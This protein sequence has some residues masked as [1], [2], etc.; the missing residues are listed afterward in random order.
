M[1]PN[2]RIFSFNP[3]IVNL[4]RSIKTRL[5]FQKQKD[6]SWGNVTMPNIEPYI[7]VGPFDKSYGRCDHCGFKVK[8]S[9]KGH[10]PW[11]PNI[12][13]RVP[14]CEHLLC[15]DC[16]SQPGELCPACEEKGGEC[17]VIPPMRNIAIERL[18]DI[19]RRILNITPYLRRL[20][21]GEFSRQ[22]T[23]RKRAYYE[24]CE[25]KLENGALSRKDAFTRNF[26]KTEATKH[27]WKLVNGEWTDET[28][29]RN[30]SP[31]EGTFNVAVGRYIKPAEP[32]LLG[33]LN[34]VL[35]HKI[36]MKGMNAVTDRKSVV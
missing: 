1:A 26:T 7:R 35:G 16:K 6:G 30:I 32:L 21:H 29:P 22:Y 36:V 2:N 27:K 11:N 14:G 25:R 23:G 4:E 12:A 18:A 15:D 31:R 28:D 34:K 5:L 17:H 13:L 19:R 8:E 3:S 33:A 24:N 10:D 20:D 9:M